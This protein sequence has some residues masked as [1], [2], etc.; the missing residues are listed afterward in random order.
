MHRELS[1]KYK[2]PSE[3]E[4]ILSQPQSDPEFLNQ[5]WWVLNYHSDIMDNSRRLRA[6]VETKL[7]LMAN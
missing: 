2:N 3:L 4:M 5:I 7:D 6:L 1:N